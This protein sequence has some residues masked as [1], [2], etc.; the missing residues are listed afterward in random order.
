MCPRSKHKKRHERPFPCTHFCGG[1]DKNMKAFG[2]KD[3]WKRHE[4]RI[5]F[6][7]NFPDEEWLCCETKT[8]PDTNKEV[9]CREFFKSAADFQRHLVD[10]HGQKGDAKP[11]LD[12]IVD[13]HRVV[14]AN[15]RY[16]WC[17]FCKEKISLDELLRPSAN[18]KMLIGGADSGGAKC[19][20]IMLQ[21]FRKGFL[22]FSDFF[23]GRCDHID[24]HLSGR[25]MPKMA[26]S[27]WVDHTTDGGKRKEPSSSENSDEKQKKKRRV[28]SSKPSKA[29]VPATVWMCVSIAYTMLAFA[30]M[31]TSTNVCRPL[32]VPMQ[33]FLL[34]VHQ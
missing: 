19:S 7:H 13:Q 8:M 24:N 22:F 33:F 26:A 27:D 16:G 9:T 14:P 1:R 18:T 31:S 28:H 34:V 5:H 12:E 25:N 6:K 10:I 20:S 17:G 29:T 11:S 32:S 15:N 2:S 21:E 3:D 23:A 30:Y 4:S